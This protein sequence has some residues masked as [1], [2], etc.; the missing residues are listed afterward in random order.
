MK[1]TICAQLSIAIKIVKEIIKAAFTN[2]SQAH[3]YHNL[4][5]LMEDTEKEELN[6]RKLEAFNKIDSSSKLLP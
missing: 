4:Q 6:R 3:L 1:L 2:P 5:N